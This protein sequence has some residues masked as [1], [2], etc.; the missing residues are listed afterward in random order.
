MKRAL[1]IVAVILLVLSA[2]VGS[3]ETGRFAV[4]ALLGY[5]LDPGPPQ[6]AEALQCSD[7]PRCEQANA[8]FNVIL[9]RRFPIGSSVRAMEAA[10]MQQGFRRPSLST[11][12]T[13]CQ[14]SYQ[15]AELNKLYVECPSWDQHWDPKN[16]LS[17]HWGH[18]PCGN[19]LDVR[20]STD[21]GGKISHLEGSYF[22]ACL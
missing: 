7:W 4:A 1:L 19:S 15:T 18:L 22:Y 3:T 8:K 5:I 21:T 16:Y 12:V 10:L 20:W 2:L 6:I 17:Y 13:R 9:K 14:P 11:A